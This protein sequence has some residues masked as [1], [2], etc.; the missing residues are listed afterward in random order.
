MP[1]KKITNDK[2]ID[3]K[4]LEIL[5]NLAPEGLTYKK[6]HK[7]CDTRL[8][9]KTEI[10]KV[11]NELVGDGLIRHEKGNQFFYIDQ[12]KKKKERKTIKKAKNQN[13][14]VGR[15]DL[16][17]KGSAYI[18]VDEL[19]DDIYVPHT[20]INRAF[21][22]D[23]V[24]VKLSNNRHKKKIEGEIIEI[25]ERRQT[26]FVGILEINS[27][28]A[29]FMPDSRKM[30][31]THFYVHLQDIG[32]AKNG[33]KVVVEFDSWGKGKKS[34]YGKV[35]EV[36]GKPGE[37]ETEIISILAEKGF[38]ISF[39]REVE[40]FVENIP[41][42]LDENEIAK[43]IDFRDITT[44]TID[45]ID[46]KDF[47]DALS[48]QKLENGNYEIGVHIADVTHYCKPETP[49]DDEAFMRATSV[50]LVDRVSP[51]LP[52]KLSNGVCSLRPNEDKYCFSAIF[53]IDE[54]ATIFKKSFSRT[55]I[56]SNR[57]FHY[58]EA[59]EI[60]DSGKGDLADELIL[61]NKISKKLRAKRIAKNSIKF[62]STEVRFKLDE[63]G[64]PLE[65]YEKPKFDTNEMIEDYMLL[66]N[67]AVAEFF[68]NY[69]KKITVP[70]VYRIHAV[71]NE[72]KIAEFSAVAAKFGHKGNY[73]T[74]ENVAKSIN[75]TLENCKGKPEQNMI[76]VLAVRSMSKA[77]YSTENIGHYGLA[78]EDYTHFTSPIRRY[79]DVMVHRILQDLL[80]KKPKF[81][82]KSL[83]EK[84]KYCS[85][86][87]KLAAEAE[88]DSVKLK[89]VEY[90]A[91]RLGEEFDGVISGVIE[92]GIFVEL[93]DNKCEGFI[94]REW[95]GADNFMFNEDM[96][97]FLG[98]HSKKRFRL[99]DELKIIVANTN[100]EN[101]TID[102]DLVSKD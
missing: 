73:T 2:P 30:R 18:L 95:L 15:V 4:I 91:E 77:I 46:A 31:N 3:E 62:G 45:P 52:E 93:K 13:T 28:F 40:F 75:K 85:E 102:F 94:R 57:R 36:I 34:P 55:V 97:E 98:Y 56:H 37:N 96:Y 19:N 35:V 71:P 32:K 25:I 10:V 54:E 1:R 12:N 82:A 89:Q 24:R 59:Q 74:P 64:K 68:T 51:M 60:I 48:I 72:D 17:S 9:T 81:D 5:K 67:Q 65:V 8:F 7:Q 70:A 50:Y 6:I 76:E 14:L 63:N 92:R 53:E 43:R 66:A 86:Q 88:R 100:I 78:F 20:K 90:L 41:F 47:D 23:K 79:P 39:P 16:T 58:Q 101:R 22:G 87:E 49:L 83:E 84:C 61:M 44:F 29:F 26:K 21:H 80:D 11:V 42:E 69:S 99:G 27:Q 38:N 33:D